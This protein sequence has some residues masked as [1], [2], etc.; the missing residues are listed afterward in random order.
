MAQSAAAPGSTAGPSSLPPRAVGMAAL[1]IVL[2]VGAGLG[3][4]AITGWVRAALDVPIQLDPPLQSL[5]QTIGPWRGKEIPV[6]E[7][8]RRIAGNDDFVSRTYRHSETGQEVSLYVGYTARPR[9]MLRH[10]PSVCFPS[11]G[12]TPT[13]HAVRSITLPDDR[14]VPIRVQEFFKGGLGNRRVAVLNY[15]VLA[16]VPTIDENSFWSLGWRTPNL[17]RDAKRYVAQVQITTR[18]GLGGDAAAERL[19]ES[20]AVDVTPGV[21]A[22]LPAPAAEDQ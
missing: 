14:V 11:A 1:V 4:R 16:G 15:Y 13:D 3:Q 10:R 12:W 5:A 9:T 17:A 7:G 20:F 18:V 21:L 2:I 8:I 19:L 22:L 6:S